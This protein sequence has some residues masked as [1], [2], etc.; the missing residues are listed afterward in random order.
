MASSERKDATANV[1]KRSRNTRG[2]PTAYRRRFCHPGG[3]PI[4]CS[5]YGPGASTSEASPQSFNSVRR[6]SPLRTFCESIPL[7]VSGFAA[8]S[9]LDSLVVGK[10]LGI[11]PH[12]DEA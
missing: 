1:Q 11:N 5:L 3:A 10:V 7:Y 9:L 12:V 4:F 6:G 2:C 8:F